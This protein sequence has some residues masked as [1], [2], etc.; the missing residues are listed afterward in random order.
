MSKAM[1]ELLKRH[2]GYLYTAIR[3]L[4]YE[5]LN[6][7]LV[8]AKNYS[9]TNCWFVEYHMKEAFIK[10]LEDRICEIKLLSKT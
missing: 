10:L 8:V 7:A 5:E 2:A 6:D 4:S 1:R 3:E 9:C